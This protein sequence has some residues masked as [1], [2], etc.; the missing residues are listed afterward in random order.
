MVDETQA[1]E[2]SAE[3][4]QKSLA[5]WHFRAGAFAIDVVLGSAVVATIALVSLTM[6]PRSAW[7]WLAISVGGFGILLALINRLLLP[8]VT[9]W[10]LGRALYGI[11]VVRGDGQAVG[12]WGL[13]LR[14]AVHLVDA[15]PL[16]VGWLWP[17][18]DSGRRTFADML[19]HTKVWRV[20]P[21]ERPAHIR[22]WTA[23][24]VLTAATVC[25]GGAVMG[26]AVVYMRDRATDETR[27]QI[28]TL[29]PRM[30]AQMLT[31]DPKSLRDDFT[32]AQSLATDRYRS[33]LTAEQNVVA[34][35]HPIINEYWVTD[36]SVQSATPGHATMLVFMQGRRGVPPEERYIT[37]TV[38]ANFAKDGNAQWRI[39]RL[40]VLA[41]PKP[42]GNR[43]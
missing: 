42:P 21:N 2:L 7:W 28:A 15:V 30:V 13:L 3:P 29:G 18:W 39:D 20:E 24:A 41:K 6:P 1:T 19:L 27:A 38:R 8:T 17:L 40:T 4:P 16:L 36:S 10:S 26:Y 14:D 35:R 34:K 22:R 43:K 25:L 32:R 31:Y 37:A 5:P 23:V 33:E 9:G 11:V 12:S